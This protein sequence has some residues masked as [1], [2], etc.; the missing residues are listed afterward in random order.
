MKNYKNFIKYIKENRQNTYIFNINKKSDE[1]YYFTSIGKNTI[2]KIVEFYKLDD[3]NYNLGFGDATYDDN[4]DII[5]YDD[6]IMSDNGDFEQVMTTI[7][8]IIYDFTSKNN[9][10]VEFKGSCDKRTSL[11]NYLIKR[12]YDTFIKDFELYGLLNN[13][14]KTYNKNEKY[15][16]LYIK[17]R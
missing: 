6:S 12:N 7:V 16:K 17:R 11:Y 9:N 10:I 1:L 8:N 4:N 5:G 15:E 14:I 2:V 3:N 13:N